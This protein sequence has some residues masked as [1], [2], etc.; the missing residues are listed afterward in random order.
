MS[1]ISSLAIVYLN[2]QALGRSLSCALVS[3]EGGLVSKNTWSL[4]V[5]LLLGDQSNASLVALSWEN[6]DSLFSNK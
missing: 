1:F 3:S 5:L 2:I 6:S 4:W